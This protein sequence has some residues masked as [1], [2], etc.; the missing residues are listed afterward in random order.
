MQQQPYAVDDPAVAA[1]GRFLQ[2][3][4]LADGRTTTGLGSPTT[5][6]LAQAVL[7]WLQ[8]LV[9]VDGRWQPTAVWESTPDL[10]DIAVEEIA[11]GRV[12]KIS[13]RV[14]G[15]SA[16]GETYDDAWTELKRKV[17]DHHG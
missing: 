14:T 12:V 2:A 7:N 15:L 13:H 1:L 5:D 6:L 3:A 10:G 8:G 9:W 11:D 17:R 4:P 16:L